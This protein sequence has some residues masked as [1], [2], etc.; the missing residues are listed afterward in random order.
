VTAIHPSKLGD[1]T[2]RSVSAS[3]AQDV[4]DSAAAL[5]LA[6]VAGADIQTVAAA[7]SRH[8]GRTIVI[9]GDLPAGTA[10]TSFINNPSA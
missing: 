3:P 10:N 8:L 4:R 5:G 7:L 1:F 2:V 9:G 6:S